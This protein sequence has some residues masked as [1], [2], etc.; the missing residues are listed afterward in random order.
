LVELLVV[1]GIIAVL[2]SL[3]LPAL[4]KARKSANTTTC[5]SN[6]RQ[7]VTAMHMYAGAYKSRLPSYG[8][9][10]NDSYLEDPDLYWWKLVAPYLSPKAAN[11]PGITFMRCPAERDPT[12]SGSYGVNYG[13]ADLA[14]FTYSSAPGIALGYDYRSSMKLMK[15]KNATFLTADVAHD[16]AIYT[17]HIYPLD[18]DAD[19]DGVN[20]SYSAIYP[21]G[22]TPYNHFDPRHEGK[23]VCSF[24]DGSARPVPLREWVTNKDRMWGP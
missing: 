3:L 7:L 1:I 6:Q 15:L 2:I 4:S 20:D 19:S 8:H 23:A 11:L 24:V 9:F 12:R 14:P 21:A 22:P 5:L 13:K 10:V 16:L 17:P 18:M